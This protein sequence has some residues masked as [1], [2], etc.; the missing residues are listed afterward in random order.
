MSVKK[1]TFHVPRLD[2]RSS[3]VTE[4]MNAT[5]DKKTRNKVRKLKISKALFGLADRR[6]PELTATP[7]RKRREKDCVELAGKYK[8]FMDVTTLEPT[9]NETQQSKDSSVHEQDCFFYELSL[10]HKTHTQWKMYDMGRVKVSAVFTG[11]SSDVQDVY[12]FSPGSVR[13]KGTANDVKQ[14]VL[15]TISRMLEENRAIRQ[16]WVTLRQMTQKP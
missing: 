14:T 15:K 2:S 4:V 16:R 8:P 10:V 6:S 12:V 1:K 5:L 9:F 13:T 11:S 7:S 3:R